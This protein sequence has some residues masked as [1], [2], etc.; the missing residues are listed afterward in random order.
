MTT[1]DSSARVA[2]GTSPKIEIMSFPTRSVTVLRSMG[3][4]ILQPY[5]TQSLDI[6][7]PAISALSHSFSLRKRELRLSFRFCQTTD[8]CPT[9]PPTLQS[10]TTHSPSHSLLTNMFAALVSVALLAV[11]ANG[12][13]VPARRTDDVSTSTCTAPATYAQGFLEDY[14]SYHERYVTLGC[15]DQHNSTFFDDCCHPMLVS[16][17]LDRLLF[18]SF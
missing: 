10:P 12:L 15:A 2:L 4:V 17:Q 1:A 9:S 16:Q 14:C 3:D 18:S 8:S 7:Q 13:A 5:K 11:S 6:N